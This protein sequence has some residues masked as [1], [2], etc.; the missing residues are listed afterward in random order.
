MLLSLSKMQRRSNSPISF[1]LDL[2]GDRW[3][4]LIIR[5]LG[6]R[7]KDSFSDFLNAG[8]GIATNVLSER[9]SRLD[10]RGLLLRE[11]DPK[12]GRKFRYQLT[13]TGRDLL[14]ILLE[15]YIWGAKYD[16]E[17][18]VDETF[19]R[20]AQEDRST[21]IAKLRAQLPE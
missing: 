5:D 8:E 9:L 7:G 17:A 11:R 15:L 16:S 1:A 3:T 12:D 13:E 20:E 6:L 21:L 18:E 4:L 14:P 19:L 10:E 2:L